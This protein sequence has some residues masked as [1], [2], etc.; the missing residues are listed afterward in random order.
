MN[1]IF[2]T[3]VNIN[4]VRHLKDI[5]IKL[6]DNERKHL[7]FTGKNGSGKTSVLDFISNYLKIFENNY[8]L[9]LIN[10]KKELEA[11]LQNINRNPTNDQIQA[12]ARRIRDLKNAINQYEGGIILQFNNIGY[13]IQELYNS[14]NYILS[15]FEAKRQ[16]KMQS[17]TGINKIDLN[18]KYSMNERP[19]EKFLQYIV[20][21]KAEKSFAR[22]DGNFNT[23]KEIDT[24]FQNFEQS[25]KEIFEDQNLEL[26]FDTKNFKFNIV[27]EGREPFDFNTLSDGYS[28]VL[29]V[30]TDLILRMETH[31]NKSYDVQGV[32]LIDEIETHLHIELQKKILPFLTRFFPKI[33]FIVTTHSPFV[34]NSIENAVI[35]DLENKIKVEDL[36]GYSYEGIIESYFD[37]D[38][39][40]D[41][42]KEKIKLYETLANTKSLNEDDQAELIK[43]RL[44]LKHIP[45]EL[46][47]ELSAK[48]NE[49]ELKRLG[50]KNG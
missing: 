47:P 36:S 21:L 50:N 43:L 23:V 17:V 25:L 9:S 28:A 30:V 40:S 34:L 19:T 45:S 18:N 46:A 27:T 37:N 41:N 38:E 7:I 2:I 8:F 12:S 4:Q 16:I 35:Y 48:F 22:D 26:K 39:Y 20:N 49:I 3:Q 14:G 13:S 11:N 1:D 44:Y 10:I 33:Q 6:S 5:E 15:Y 32:V 42:I 29:N 31:K 24:W